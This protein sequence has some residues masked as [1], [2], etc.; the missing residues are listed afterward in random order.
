MW[1]RRAA[2]AAHDAP[3]AISEAAAGE[4][5]RLLD[6]HRLDYW[7]I[8]GWGV[9]ALLGRVT[10][11]H[12]DLDLLL[13]VRQHARAWRLL[14][15]HQFSLQ[16]R[17]E[18]NVDIPGE[19]LPGG[20]QPTA[21]VLED[22]LGRQLDVHVL[23]D[24]SPVARPLWATDQQFIAGALEAEGQIDGLRVRCMSAQMQL[25]AHEGYELPPTQHADVVLVRSLL[26]GDVP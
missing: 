17:W 21:Y 24:R 23:D 20:L 1:L 7:V 25:L 19:L 18:E 11:A 6:A 13:P 4:L 5:C 3:V 8:G 26:D 22:P 14:H 15:Q 12:K 10:R 16:Y 9:D 2:T